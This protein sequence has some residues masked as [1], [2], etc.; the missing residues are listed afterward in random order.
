MRPC[1]T[2]RGHTRGR[3]FLLIVRRFFFSRFFSRFTRAGA[4]TRW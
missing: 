1:M 3:G 2:P 4:G